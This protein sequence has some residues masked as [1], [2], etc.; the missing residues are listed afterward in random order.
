MRCRH[1]GSS[2]NLLGDWISGLAA[3]ADPLDARLDRRLPRYRRTAPY[4]SVCPPVCVRAAGDPET[5]GDTRN[6]GHGSRNFR[7]RGGP[8]AQLRGTLRALDGAR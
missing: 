2:L 6:I 5:G 4:V 1:P 3:F 7:W 8:D